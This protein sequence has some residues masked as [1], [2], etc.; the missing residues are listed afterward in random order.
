MQD[1]Q[2]QSEGP[3]LVELLLNP[4]AKYLPARP[5]EDATSREIISYK[6]ELLSVR[7]PV[8]DPA[9]LISHRRVAVLMERLREQYDLIIVNGPAA[10]AVR[11][12]RPLSQI[13]DHKNGSASGKDR[14]CQ[15]VESLVVAV[16]LKKKRNKSKQ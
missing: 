1:I 3:D 12:P 9:S 14:V 7:E 5:E 8:K 16:A 4:P 6:P 15:Y 2:R 13:A 10:T 11:D